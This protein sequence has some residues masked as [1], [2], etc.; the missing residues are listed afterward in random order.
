MLGQQ[1]PRDAVR[2][3]PRNPCDQVRAGV[4]AAR[5]RQ[6]SGVRRRDALASEGQGSA[7]LRGAKRGARGSGRAPAGGNFAYFP[8][9]V[10][11]FTL[12]IRAPRRSRTPLSALHLKENLRDQSATGSKLQRQDRL[13]LP[14]DLTDISYPPLAA[15]I[16]R[17]STS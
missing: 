13:I 17:E 14:P 7:G 16:P 1:R 8:L 15:Q 10:V 4:G 12:L 11:F 2:T 5:W 6:P 3:R 9:L